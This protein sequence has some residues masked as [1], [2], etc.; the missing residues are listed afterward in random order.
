LV[1]LIPG[2]VFAGFYFFSEGSTSSDRDRE[3]STSEPT[4]VVTAP[5]TPLITMPS[6][7][8]DE[9]PPA[10]SWVLEQMQSPNPDMTPELFKWHIEDFMIRVSTGSREA[11]TY[12]EGIMDGR[13]GNIIVP[14]EYN[15]VT[16]FVNGYAR[17]NRGGRE[18][19]GG[20][21][22]DGLW[23]LVNDCG[24]L[25]VPAEYDW[26]GDVD[27]VSGLVPVM[28]AQTGS[29]TENRDNFVWRFIDVLTGNQ[30]FAHQFDSAGRFA[31]GLAPVEKDGEWGYINTSGEFVIEL[32]F[33]WA[34]VFNEYGLAR[35]KTDEGEGFI[36]TYGEFVVRPIYNTVWDYIDGLARVWIGDDWDTGR[37]AMIN[38]SG[39][40]M[41][42][43]V[44]KSIEE[45]DPDS[46][47]ARVNAGGNLWGFI[48]RSGDVVIPATFDFAGEFSEGLAAVRVGDKMGF[49]D[50][51]GRIVIA[52]IYDYVW[53]FNGG[54]AAVAIG[55]FEGNP[56]KVGF[57]NTSGTNVVPL[58]YDA[59]IYGD[60]IHYSVPGFQ[61]G[62][63]AVGVGTWET[64]GGM[65]YGF[66]NE[67]GTLEIQAQY[68]SIMFIGN[69]NG[70]AYFWALKDGEWEILVARAG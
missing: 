21:A 35:V 10:P 31:Q 33:E 18:F 61:N 58:E 47:L 1:V 39:E 66:V 32:Q 54:F 5:T 30:A 40:I 28:K 26:I 12:R 19:Y 22:T 51:S 62:F 64:V 55:G 20:Y 29:G 48:N 37:M 56:E 41:G 3:E 9:P 8:I 45:F 65:K 2:G 15:S 69:E 14:I 57:I 34:C 25:V 23:G 50:T 7:G 6:L 17:V 43:G 68:D 36:N 44:F 42:Q 38:T 67:S 59:L 49:I 46:G 24:Q 16:P 11:G 52:A 70:R 63:A 60:F 13:T 27:P 53:D 4:T